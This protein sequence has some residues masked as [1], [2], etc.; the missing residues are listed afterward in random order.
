M[1]RQ[2][3]A[4]AQIYCVAS[5]ASIDEHMAELAAKKL[6]IDVSSARAM[7]HKVE[8]LLARG[9][10]NRYLNMR[11]KVPR[12]TFAIINPSQ[13]ERYNQRL[14]AGV[15]P[16]LMCRTSLLVGVIFSE[17]PD[18]VLVPEELFL[19]QGWPLVLQKRG[20]GRRNA[21]LPVFLRRS[22]YRKHLRNMAGN[23]MHITSLFAAY[24]FLFGGLQHVKDTTATASLPL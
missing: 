13:N 20:R 9:D 17:G 5:Q 3:V 15:A 1:A 4:D 7:P 16:A 18:R 6:K 14:N 21:A 8:D 22:K 12:D 10:R 24:L 23:G 19:V 11:A 2:V